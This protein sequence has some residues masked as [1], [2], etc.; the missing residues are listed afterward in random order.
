MFLFIQN[1]NDIVLNKLI[2]YLVSSSDVTLKKKK[3][4]KNNRTTKE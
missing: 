3:E 1:E 2:K 4:G